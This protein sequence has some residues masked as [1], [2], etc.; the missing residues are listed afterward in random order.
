MVLSDEMSH[1]AFDFVE[2]F[3]QPIYFF[4]AQANAHTTKGRNNEDWLDI[5]DNLY[6]IP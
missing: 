2:D 4:L 1:D 3:T 6:L 5:N